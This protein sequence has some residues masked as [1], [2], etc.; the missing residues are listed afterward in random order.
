MWN[1]LSFPNLCLR[2]GFVVVSALFFMN[3]DGNATEP[4]EE[5]KSNDC[6]SSSNGSVTICVGVTPFFTKRIVAT[7]HH[8]KDV[9]LCD[10]AVSF[11]ANIFKQL[12]I[13]NIHL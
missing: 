5:H 1:F 4:F 12:S 8:K 9:N 13:K 11:M 6:G 3:H 7:S 2:L 10:N